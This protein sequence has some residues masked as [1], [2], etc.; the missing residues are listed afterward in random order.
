[1]S[2]EWDASSYHRLSDQQFGWGKKV[3]ARAP[4]RGDETVLDAGCGTGRV[5]AELL[6][7]LPRG[8]VVAVDLSGEMLRGARRELLPRYCGRVR[9]VCAD[10]QQLP[11]RERFD[12]IFSTATFHWAKDHD[13]LFRSL[14]MALRPGGWLVAQC[15]GGANL[16]RLRLRTHELMQSP[17]FAQYFQNWSDPWEFASPEFTGER[18]RR[19]GFVDVRTW[20]EP[21]G[22][23][24]P[25]AH[26]F[27]QYLATVTLHRHIERIAEPALRSE[28]L[29]EIVQ[30]AGADPQFALDYWRLNIDGRK[31]A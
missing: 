28:F 24:L 19:T 7:R 8:L 1:M 27:Q 14:Y 5:T 6:D 30:Q 10:L 29:G 13:R 3:L 31:P 26:T 23:T 20:L 21:A 12:G 17:R 22:F 16:A 2:R 15:G 25:D 18:M 9:F 11:F 4:L